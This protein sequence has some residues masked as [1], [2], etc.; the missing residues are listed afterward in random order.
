MKTLFVKVN[1]GGVGKSTISKNIAVGMASI[2]YNVA[3][4]SFDSQNDSLILLGKEFHEG[5][6]GLKALIQGEEEDIRIK[7]REN[8]DYYPLETD[9]I[10]T[11]LKDKLSATIEDLKSKYDI[12]I[13]DGAPS[14]DSPLSRMGEDIADEI[15]VPI[16]LEVLSINGISRMLHEEGESKIDYIIPNLYHRR[17]SEKETYEELKE[18]LE[19]TSI[20]LSEPIPN[21]SI[22]TNLKSKGKSI[23]ESSSKAASKLQDIYTSIIK[24]IIGR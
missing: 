23:Y 16:Q 22:E 2:E 5:D 7:V 11:H 19:D 9:K 13:I 18:F 20:F 14:K 6:K 4:V 12:V 17:K 3:L 21:S 1:K 15:L 10:S 8:L 24:E